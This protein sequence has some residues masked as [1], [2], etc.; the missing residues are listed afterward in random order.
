MPAAAMMSAPAKGRAGLSVLPMLAMPSPVVFEGPPGPWP[1][2]RDCLPRAPR[3]CPARRSGCRRQGWRQQCVSVGTLRRLACRRPGIIGHDIAA[4]GNHADRVRRV[5]L[6][7]K[8]DIGNISRRRRRGSP[9]ENTR[10]R[11]NIA[12][13]RIQIDGSGSPAWRIFESCKA[14]SVSTTPEAPVFV[15]SEQIAEAAQEV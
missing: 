13:D 14:C 5:I 11:R 4:G 8:G 15:A 1:P 2:S 10:S 3:A 7:V 12:I 6:Q 9:W